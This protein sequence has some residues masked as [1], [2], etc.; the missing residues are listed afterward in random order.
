[1]SAIGEFRLR[2]LSVERGLRLARPPSTRAGL[3]PSHLAT[4]NT[5][6]QVFRR[7]LTRRHKF[8]TIF[9]DLAPA[10]LLTESKPSASG[11]LLTTYLLFVTMSANLAQMHSLSSG[12]TE[13]YVSASILETRHVLVVEDE[14]D[15]AELLIY[16]LRRTGY[17][18]AS[19]P[20]GLKAL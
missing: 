11:D 5:S 18:V 10:I 3:Y 17:L 14:K 4:A 12:N 9:P 2:K 19:A 16:N 8:S 7:T 1:T 15:L 20:T 13:G 6:R